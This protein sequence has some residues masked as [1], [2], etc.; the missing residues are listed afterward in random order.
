M[1][2]IVMKAFSNFTTF[3]KA[4]LLVSFFAYI[5]CGA[6]V[7]SLDGW[8]AC[9]CCIVY[10]FYLVFDA[11]S[12][13]LG[14]I[15]LILSYGIYIYFNVKEFYFGELMQS[16]V[17]IVI[18]FIAL[19]SWKRHSQEDKKLKINKISTKESVLSFAAT[20]AFIAIFYAISIAI[21]SNLALLNSL[22]L[23]FVLLEYYF[24]FRRTILKYIAGILS[25]GFYITLWIL[26]MTSPTDYSLIFVVNGFLNVVWCIDGIVIWRRIKNN[27]ISK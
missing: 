26:A 3:Q 1:Y 25:C 21:K 11:N 17:A 4:L 12:N 5:I 23:G 27:Q 20:A 18:N 7:N 6:I 22:S 8:I 24:V 16:I 14:F 2:N 19:F 9:L 10:L 13:Y 15:W